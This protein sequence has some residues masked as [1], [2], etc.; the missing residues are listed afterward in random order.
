RRLARIV[1]MD[2]AELLWRAQTGARIAS[3][4]ARVALSRPLWN[5]RRVL[6]IISRESP[7]DP[8][9][10][11]AAASRWQDAHRGVADYIL[12]LPPK[13]VI[14]PGVRSNLVERIRHAYPASTSDARTRGDQLLAG[15]YDLLGYRDLR[16]DHGE[17]ASPSGA[18]ASSLIDWSYDPV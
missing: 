15:N 14:S 17:T 12:Q 5:R 10:R 1:S 16:F 13:F 11:A 7:F 6:R 18:S 2:R 4:R 8:V 3:D 9:H